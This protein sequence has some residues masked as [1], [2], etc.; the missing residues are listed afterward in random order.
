VIPPTTDY[1]APED[2]YGDGTSPDDL[3]QDDYRVGAV[4]SDEPADQPAEAG[5]PSPEPDTV[6]R[7]QHG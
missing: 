2:D 7:G 5:A 4:A 3:P 1:G 6:A